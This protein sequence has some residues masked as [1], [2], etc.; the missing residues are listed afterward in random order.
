MGRPSPKCTAEFK[1]RA[2][3]L[4]RGRGCAYAEPARELG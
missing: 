2:A 4:Y 3:G 1:Q